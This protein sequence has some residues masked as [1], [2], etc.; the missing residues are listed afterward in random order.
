MYLSSNGTLLVKEKKVDGKVVGSKII[1]CMCNLPFK[2]WFHYFS[3]CLYKI[4]HVKWIFLLIKNKK[5]FS[6]SFCFIPPALS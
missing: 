2:K 3:I 5:L 4:G 1:R 6:G